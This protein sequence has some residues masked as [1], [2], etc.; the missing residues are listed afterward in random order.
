MRSAKESAEH[1]SYYAKKPWL[2]HYDFWV[3]ESVSYPRQ[4]VYRALEIGASNYPNRP[5]TVFFGAE[6]TFRELKEQAYR[7]A[8][9]LTRFGIVKGDRV[10]IM[11]PNC[12]QFPVSFFAVL[13]TGATVV[14][15]NPT[16]TP[17]EFERLA[18]DS[19]IRALIVT[20]LNAASIAEM[21]PSTSIE[22]VIVTGLQDYMPEGVAAGYVAERKSQIQPIA[23]LQRAAGGM[24]IHGFSKLIQESEPQY[25]RVAINTEEDIAALQYTGGT[26]GTPKGAML[27]HFNLFANTVQSA[28]WRSYFSTPDGERMLIVIPLFH[29]YGMTVGMLLGA[30]QGSTLILIPKFDPDLLIDAIPRYRPTFFPAVPTLYVSLLNHPKSKETDFSSIK[31]FNSGSAP[32]PLDVTERFEALTGCVL[33]QGYGLSETSPTTHSTTQL[34]LRKPESCGIPFPD[35]ES[36]IVDIETGTT[37]MPVNELGELCVRG[38]QVMKGYWNQP[39]ET[40]RVLRQDPD[41]RGPWFYTGDIGRMD[42]DGYFYIVQRKK[43]MIIVGGF[44]VYPSEV[45]EVLYSHPAVMEAGV[46]GVADDYKGERVK[47]FVSLKPGMNATESDL[48]DYCRKGLARFKVP[49]EIEFL[50]GL[51]KTAVGKILHRSLRDIQAS[52]EK[53]S[54]I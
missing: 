32:L 11:L 27:T 28:L 9:A 33:R 5:A 44:N 49:T 19:G 10:G 16:Y 25:I 31:Y 26:T 45:E 7:L 4:P 20:D 42:E 51:P 50:P 12:P 22:N 40:A 52:K 54:G 53:H 1:E 24:P 34:G 13:R 23:D 8:S 2:K 37:E 30:L 47:A 17:R 35:T 38:P 3:P 39:D 6:L 29:V 36:K 21:L 43:D 46:I 41:G 18:K 48:L 14:S 15:I